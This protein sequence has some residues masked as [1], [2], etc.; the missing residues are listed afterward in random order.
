MKKHINLW[1]VTFLAIS[2]ALPIYSMAQ[3]TPTLT[4]E[5]Y[6]TGDRISGGPIKTFSLAPDGSLVVYLDGPF[7]FA[8][9]VPEITVDDTIYSGCT[10][11]PPASVSA[12]QGATLSFRINSTTT[13]A[14]FSGGS[15]KTGLVVDPE[16]AA[17]SFAT[18][19]PTAPNTATGIFTWTTGGTGGSVPVGSYLAVFQAEVASSET[20]RSQLPVMINIVPP[21]YT[22]T[23]NI[24]GSGTVTKNPDQATYTANPIQTVQLTATPGSGYSFSGWSGDL[25]GSA[26]PGSI[27]MNANKTV[28]AT[29]NQIPK[30]SLT[31]YVSPSG[32]GSVSPSSGSYDE[33]TYVD[34]T[35][36]AA[37]GYTFSS[38]SG[39]AAGD[40]TSNNTAHIYMNANRSITANFTQTPSKYTLTTYV[41]PSGAG[42]VSPSSGSYDADAYADLTAT[43]AS[44]YTFSSWSGTAAGDTTSGNTAH[45]YMN[46]NRSITANFAQSQTPSGET[47]VWGDYPMFTL[48]AGQ[49]KVYIVNI[50]AQT[51]KYLKLGI[52]GLTMNT[53]GTFSWTFP[54][55]RVLPQ[56]SSQGITDIVGMNGA[57]Q[58]VLRAGQNIPDPYVPGGNHV[59]IIKA[60]TSSY[61][62]VFINAE[63]N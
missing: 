50:P 59:L 51:Y 34:L 49:Q 15:G 43:A 61:F 53:M 46:A 31:T 9:L 35:A 58:L 6:T 44:G 57:G 2:M 42:S 18:T 14:V 5:S 41:N 54:D 17:T 16:P 1:L 21:G 63:A 47:W 56:N 62:K 27:Q 36:T 3:T 39:I 19:T 22:L 24:V 26:N 60:T 40:T 29:F 23:V 52:S 48:E 8:S 45:I 11:S 33:N 20:T 28:T 55:G 12:T 4:L 30:Y 25:S 10:V 38:W 13:G 32:A 7:N 37:S